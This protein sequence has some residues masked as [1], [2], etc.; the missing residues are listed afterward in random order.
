MKNINNY[1]LEKLHIGKTSKFFGK[2]PDGKRVLV[3][4]NDTHTKRLIEK[5]MGWNNGPTALP[6]HKWSIYVYYI[7][8]FKK[9]VI[10]KYKNETLIYKYFE[11]PDEY[12]DNDLESTKMSVFREK[13]RQG[14]IK[15]KDLCEIYVDEEL[16]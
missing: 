12:E 16:Y 11:L 8:D 2:I 3:A 5:A 9:Y 13:L 4:S 14:E 7:K 10:D 1:I 6:G 15:L